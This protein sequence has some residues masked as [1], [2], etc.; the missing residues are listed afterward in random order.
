MDAPAA[1]EC[2]KLNYK[3]KVKCPENGLLTKFK[4]AEPA[5]LV[6]AGRLAAG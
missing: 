3:C 1:D 2:V 4:R 6:K 5:G